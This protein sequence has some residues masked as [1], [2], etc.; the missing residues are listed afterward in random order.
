MMYLLLLPFL[1]LSACHGAIDYDRLA[2]NA[3]YEQQRE[4]AI[5]SQQQ[6]VEELWQWYS[7]VKA[8][9]AENQ[10]RQQEQQQQQAQDAPKE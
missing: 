6:K 10:R 9:A 1:F 7:N 4:Q 2:K 5:L 3:L 8:V